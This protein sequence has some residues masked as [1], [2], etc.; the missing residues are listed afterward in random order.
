MK[1][2]ILLVGLLISTFSFSQKLIIK[3][4]ESN[5]FYSYSESKNL[6]VLLE[7]SSLVSNDVVNTQY[8]IDL[9]ENTSSFYKNG[10]LTSVLPINVTK[11]NQTQLQIHILEEGFDYGLIVNTDIKN[12]SVTRYVF[13]S[14]LT[15]IN[16]MT[17]FEIVKPS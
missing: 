9:D 1:N 11:I 2:L 17:N 7:N 5:T 12:E 15:E 14:S 13:Y 4:Q 10:K 16:V 8:I 3:I 6:K